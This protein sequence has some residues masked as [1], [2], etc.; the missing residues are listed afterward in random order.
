MS[1]VA[2][3]FPS[4][5]F[6]FPD[7]SFP[8]AK[9]A[10]RPQPHEKLPD[11]VFALSP[12]RL[13]EESMQI[14]NLTPAGTDSVV[15]PDRNVAQKARLR[16]VYPELSDAELERAKENLDRYLALALRIFLHRRES[17]STQQV[18]TDAIEDP[19]LK[20]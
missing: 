14:S 12:S 18:L 13:F 7:L 16:R 2:D 17:N 10:R 6:C 3:D 5:V 4:A 9:R 19:N 8:H 1:G 20:V 11:S 15:I